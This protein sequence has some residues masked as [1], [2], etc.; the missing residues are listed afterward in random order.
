[1]EQAGRVSSEW[2]TAGS[3]PSRRVY[4]VTP[5]GEEYL[6]WWMED[7][8]RTR[9]EID[10]LIAAY[11]EQERRDGHQGLESVDSEAKDVPD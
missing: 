11:T 6:R 7:L 1:M 2:D 3:G 5:G 8:R 10:D 4:Q 9:D